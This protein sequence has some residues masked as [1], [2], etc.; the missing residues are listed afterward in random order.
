MTIRTPEQYI[1][2]LRD[3]RVVY[4][5]GER[6]KDVTTHPIMRV[7]IDWMAMDYELQHDP[8]YKKLLTEL[9]D[10]NDLVSFSFIP[11]T[12]KKELLRLREIVKLCARIYFG[13]PPRS[14]YIGTDALSAVAVVANRVDKAF[15]TGYSQRVNAYRE[16]LQK[17]D[18]S[19]ALGMTDVKGDRGVRPSQ[20]KMHK[21]YYVRVVDE[22]KDGIIV[23]G[24]KSHVCG[25]PICNEI[26]VIPG[27][28]MRED[29]KEYA[30]SF[31]IQANA[32]GITFISAE[33]VI[34]DPG[35]YF[36]YPISSSIYINEAMVI[37][38]D[39]FI[40]NERIFLKK[41][42]QHAGDITYMFG[43]FHRTC[44]ETCRAIE[45]E[46]LTGAMALMAEYNGV[47][48]ASHVQ[49]KI[50]WMIS[51]AEATEVLSKAACEHCISEPESNLVYPNPVYAN[52]AKLF[53]TDNW[54]QATKFVQDIAGGLV[55]TAPSSKDYNNPEIHDLLDKYLGGKNG[56]SSEYRLRLIK[57]IRDL[58]SCYED[59]TALNAEGSLAAE[60]LSIYTIADFDRYKAAARRAAGIKDGT[61]HP[62]FSKLPQFPKE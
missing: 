58:T 27:R 18:A 33:P 5:M 28:A 60:K 21:D 47:E 23:R 55:A 12:S 9:N 37:F 49:D 2:S 30:V 52:I 42:W 43:N 40:P 38:D 24:A 7:A 41:E 14:R 25:A 10:H 3:G 44:A 56:Q 32:K 45:L 15:N 46:L 11:K 50:S 31:A 53:F 35:N 8:K 59:V 4:C 34:K 54:H 1:E 39:V 13:K 29:D 61:E 17:T 36:D 20:Q 26:I 22:N 62:I 19:I 6:V 48:R 51:Y 57:L 16:L